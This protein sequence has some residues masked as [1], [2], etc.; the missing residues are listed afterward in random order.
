MATESVVQASCSSVR[1]GIKRKL[2]DA[3][4]KSVQD[5]GANDRGSARRRGGGQVMLLARVPKIEVIARTMT[6]TTATTTAQ[7][8]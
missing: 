3:G 2:Q 1:K 4:I 7:A 6:M 5:Q 8:K